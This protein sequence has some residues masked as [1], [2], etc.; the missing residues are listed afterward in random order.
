[1]ELVLAGKSDVAISQLATRSLYRR[2]LA[3]GA[4]ISEYQPQ[5]LHSKLIIVDDAVYVGSSNL[6]PRSL[7]IN[8]ELMLRLTEPGVVAEAREVFADHLRHS[9]A[10]QPEAWK[11]SHGWWARLKGRWACFVLGR[12]DRLWMMRE[13]K[14]LR[15]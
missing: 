8:Y 13:L 7:H 3:A 2:F 12:L 11:A 9:R 1:M 6:D 10:I 15:S 14:A 5:V 4:R